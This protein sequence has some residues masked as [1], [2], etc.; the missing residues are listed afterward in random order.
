[1][2]F[3]KTF[4]GFFMANKN[5]IS[6]NPHL[7]NYLKSNTHFKKAATKIHTTKQSTLDK[8]RNSFDDLLKE[9]DNLKFIEDDKTTNNKKTK[10]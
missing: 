5:N 2:N 3:F 8:L 1:M 6:H 9:E 4:A 7:T 10:K